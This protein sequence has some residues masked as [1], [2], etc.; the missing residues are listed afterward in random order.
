MRKPFLLFSNPI[1]LAHLFW[2]KTLK[3]GDI[4]IDATVGNG[5]DTLALAKSLLKLGGGTLY[6]FDIQ[7]AAIKATY[8]RIQLFAPEFLPSLHLMH[9]SHETFPITLRPNSVSLIVYNLGYLPAADKTIT[10]LSESTC[11][12]ISNALTLLSPGGY[13][14]ILCYPGHAEGAKEF[15]NIQ[16]ISSGLDKTVYCS[17]IH[18][19]SNRNKSPAL[20]LIQKNV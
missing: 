20:I 2:E 7:E 19:F 15:Q 16:E 3:K 9:T 10:T 17:S 13:L 11:I 5:K 1:E 12:S 18:L 8:D 4:V 14:S 6:G